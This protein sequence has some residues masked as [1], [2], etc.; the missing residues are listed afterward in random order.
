[1]ETLYN[2]EISFKK[3]NSFYDAVYEKEDKVKSCKTML[4][5]LPRKTFSQIGQEKQ[6]NKQ[7]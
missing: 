5:M 4:G 7:N 6:C 1:M 2:E 3:Q